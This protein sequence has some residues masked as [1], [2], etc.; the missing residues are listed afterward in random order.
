ME[1]LAPH[2]I[3]I[4]GL[5]REGLSTY[6]FLRQELPDQH[7]WL[8]DDKQVNAL[9]EAWQT[10]IRQDPLT[11]ALQNQPITSSD[12]LPTLIIKTPGL[13]PTHPF[14]QQAVESEIKITSNAQLF[15]DQLSKL[16]T[17]PTTIG[18]TGTKGKSTTTSLIY[19]VLK[20]SG[21]TTF[22]AGNIGV[23]P[24]DLVNELRAADQD[25]QTSYVVLELS[26]HQLLDLRTSPQVA[27]VQ[28]IVPEHLDYYETFDQYVEAK[29]HVTRFQTAA[30]YVVFN[31]AYE[32]PKKLADLSA[33]TKL[34]F[35]IETNDE[36]LLYHGQPVIKLNQIP[37]PGT[38]NRENVMPAVVIGVHFE[39]S[40]TQIGAA[41][42]S[43]KPLEHRLEFVRDLNGVEYYNDSLATVQDAAVAALQAF[44]G[45]PVILIA[46]GYDRGLDYTDLAKAILSH[47]VKT[48]ILFKPTGER[49]AETVHTL[50]GGQK[51]P[52]IFFPRSMSE[53]V[54]EAR[55]VAQ[56]G[57][58]VLMSPA[59]PSFGEFKD[60]AD[61]GQ[62]FKREVKALKQHEV[63]SQRPS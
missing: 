34:T 49:I 59:S 38:H 3:L 44:A 55:K 50:A 62:Q 33:G 30:D 60:Y 9:S 28:N 12:D 20:E 10:V 15:F 8:Y 16:R 14:L 27:V 2:R 47:P 17:K 35:S 43:F 39:L 58:V 37:L 23:P 48:L 42:A 61:R 18:V 26:S 6:H 5:G 11:T 41:I 25:N 63:F 52:T 24:L 51:L 46:G 45:K 7:L 53:A 54:H 32:L 4:L 29:S 40:L 57:D 19:H 22:L 21:F 31:P 36:F 56:A 1:Q 13:P